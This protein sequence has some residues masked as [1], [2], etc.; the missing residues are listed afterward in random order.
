MFTII[1]ES[2]TLPKLS[3]TSLFQKFDEQS[4]I[5]Q[6]VIEELK[7]TKEHPEYIVKPSDIDELLALMKL[8]GDPIVKK[9]IDA[10]IKGDIV[11]IFDKATSVIP[12]T[13]PFIVLTDKDKK[14]KVHIFADRFISNLQ[15]NQEY[16]SLM[17]VLEASYLALQLATQPN[18]FLMNSQLMLLICYIYNFMSIMPLEQKLYMKGDNLVKARLYFI[19]YFYKMTYVQHILLNG[20]DISVDNIPFKRIISDKVDPSVLSQVV[21]DIKN[22]PDNSIMNVVELL[23][24]INPVRYKDLSSQYVPFFSTSCGVSLIFALENIQYLFLLITSAP[25][26]T[27]LTQ[28]G[29]N[30]TVIQQ[31][32]KVISLLQS[33]V[34]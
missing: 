30:Q 11:I 22:M 18:K 21:D 1:Q 8:N 15:S 29:L 7:K 33:I 10:F 27:T 31:C 2:V 25:N 3:Q 6:L 34:S 12:Q 5:S 24:K 17:A 19:A 16:R 9:A 4:N 32:R 20:T 14:A 13:L 23:K 28:Y 26:K